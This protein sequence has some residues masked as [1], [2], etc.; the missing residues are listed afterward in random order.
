[1]AGPISEEKFQG[2][3]G[4]SHARFGGPGENNPRSRSARF[5]VGCFWL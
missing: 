5:C 2:L 1:M 4:L 3:Q